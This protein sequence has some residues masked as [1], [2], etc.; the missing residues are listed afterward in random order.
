[1]LYCI[2][3]A[4]KSHPFFA[5]AVWS[6]AE[7]RPS[8]PICRVPCRSSAPQGSAIGLDTAVNVCSCPPNRKIE[9][10]WRGGCTDVEGTERALLFSRQAP[11]GKNGY[12][13]GG[14]CCVET[15]LAHKADRLYRSDSASFQYAHN[16]SAALQLICVSTGRP[17]SPPPPHPGQPERGVQ[18]AWRSSQNCSKMLSKVPLTSKGG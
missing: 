2:S 18:L 14:W 17:R 11:F 4:G 7:G 15:W 8:R 1:M 6:A 13:H 12:R 3:S 16:S 9:T 10:Y 5:P